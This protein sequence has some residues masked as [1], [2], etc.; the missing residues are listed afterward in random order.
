MNVTG[1]C[2]QH[3][4]ILGPLGR[5]EMK[6]SHRTQTQMGTLRVG[7]RIRTY[8]VLAVTIAASW[9]T[10]HFG[11]DVVIESTSCERFG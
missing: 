11:S 4:W 10:S 3:F 6:T 5:E 2:G 8:L 9:T 1:N 7:F